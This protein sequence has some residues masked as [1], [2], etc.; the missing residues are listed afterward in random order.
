MDGQVVPARA[1]GGTGREVRIAV[2]DILRIADG[3][4]VEHWGLVDQ[5][6]LLTQLGAFPAA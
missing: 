4:L 6:G 2:M 3:Q 5:L 1:G